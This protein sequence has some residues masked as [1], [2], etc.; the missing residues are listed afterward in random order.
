VEGDIREMSNWDNGH[1]GKMKA[2]EK[3]EE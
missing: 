3:E 2:K 1:N